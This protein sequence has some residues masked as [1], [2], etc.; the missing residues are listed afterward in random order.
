[1][2]ETPNHYEVLGVSQDASPEEI[3]HA[4]RKLARRLHPDVNP[5]PEAAE[6][7][8]AVTYA[9][10]VLSD[11]QKR[12]NYDAGG[13]EQA[14]AGGADPFGF[15]DIFN[16]FFGQ[17]GAS[18]G[19]A[20]RQQA[21]D[22]LLVHTEITLQEAV[23][24]VEKSVEV[25]TARTCDTCHGTGA[26]P[27]THPETCGTCQG[28]GSV[29]QRV[30]SLLG[31]V[32]TRTVC[33]DCHGYGTII[34]TPCRD[35]GGQGRVR[36]KEQI[37]VRI[38]GGVDDGMRIQMSGRGPVGPGNG[39]RGDLY[40]QVRVQPDEVFQRDGDDLL[41]TV[42]VSMADAALGAT[43][44][45]ETFDGPKDISID[46][47]TQSGDI[48]VAKGLGAAR[49]RGRGRGDLRI[50]FSVVTPTKLNQEQRELLERFRD[51]R[52]PHT[53]GLI[54]FQQGLFAKLRDRF[55]RSTG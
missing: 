39:P 45:V 5:S 8:K 30:R 7:F 43:A 31:T 37:T 10:E 41:A 36:A 24:G 54:R 44:T 22:D 53:P 17:G 16:A 50:A 15:G 6:Q 27:G 47:G 52:D 46:P 23:F 51:A 33:P 19:P 26:A 2:A 32:S 48:H 9:Y 14:A 20:S 38:P 21:G 11:P 25:S 40:V 34:R 28:S 1:V 35:C 12:A 42:E 49:L 55:S 18:Q 3:K 29:L 13:S 4:Y